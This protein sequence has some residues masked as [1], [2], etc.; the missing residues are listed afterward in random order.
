MEEGTIMATVTVMAMVT[1]E[2]AEWV[3]T[4]A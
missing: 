1:E 4:E 2:E 3:W